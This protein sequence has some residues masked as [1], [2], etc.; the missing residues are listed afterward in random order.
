[1]YGETGQYSSVWTLLGPSVFS[2]SSV[3][4]KPFCSNSLRNHLSSGVKYQLTTPKI[5]TVPK[6]TQACYI[7]FNFF[8]K[9]SQSYQTRLTKLN[10]CEVTGKVKGDIIT[11]NQNKSKQWIN[12][13]QSSYWKYD[14][15]EH[16]SRCVKW[17]AK[18]SQV[19]VRWLES[20]ACHCQAK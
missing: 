3:F 10:V 7:G 4:S 13:L 18:F 5:V 2:G 8:F 12:E 9:V 11:F 16:S 20:A 17:Y 6:I 1:M 14:R 15:I 19:E